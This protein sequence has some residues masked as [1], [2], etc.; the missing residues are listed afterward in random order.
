MTLDQVMPWLKGLGENLARLNWHPIFKGICLLLEE[1]TKANFMAGRGPDGI[2]WKRLAK[3]RSRP[4]DK[5]AKMPGDA[6]RPLR[7]TDKLMG[8]FSAGHEGHVEN[9]TG[10]TLMWGTNL[11]YAAPHQFGH[12]FNR[13]EKTRKKPWVFMG[14]SGLPVFTRKIKAH[15]QTIPPR[16]F[17]GLNDQLTEDIGSL[18]A[19]EIEKQLGFKPSL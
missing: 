12:T 15:Q 7:D 17:V 4:R 16:P 9:I 10:S 11:V 18:V 1:S 2:P 6:Q 13:P 3:P 5:R 14:D 19:D 8:S